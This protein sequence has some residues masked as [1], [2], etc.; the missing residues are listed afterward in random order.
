MRIMSRKDTIIIAV[1]GTAQQ[2]RVTN[3]TNRI[4]Q[5]QADE[6]GRK[7]HLQSTQR[8]VDRLQKLRRTLAQNNVNAAASGVSLTSGTVTDLK[9]GSIKQFES[10]QLTDRVNTNSFVNNLKATANFNSQI[11][12][13]QNQGA[14]VR[15]IGSIATASIGADT[16]ATKAKIKSEGG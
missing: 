3:A 4:N 1:L 16:D 6:Q 2:I 10:D 8:E 13:L 15:G 12:G 7:A 14:L 9:Q 5:W 11:A